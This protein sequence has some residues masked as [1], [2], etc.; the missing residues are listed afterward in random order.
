VVQLAAGIVGV[1]FHDIQHTCV[2]LLTAGASWLFRV[3]GQG[4]GE[5]PTFRFSGQPR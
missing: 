2:P 1:R 3:C 4:G 5:P